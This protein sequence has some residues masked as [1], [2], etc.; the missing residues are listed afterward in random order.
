[1]IEI[2][3]G[4]ATPEQIEQML[5]ELKF[6]IKVAVDLERRVLAGGGEMHFYCEQALLEDGSL[7]QDIW[8][9]SFRPENKQIIYESM[10]NLRPRQNRS[11][12]I[13]DAKIRKQ[14]ALIIMEFL[15]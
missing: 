1:M 4:R 2:I 10:V 14:V 3:R 11:M 7:Q 12:E 15:G 5:Q 8:A 13:Q 6:Y 9:A